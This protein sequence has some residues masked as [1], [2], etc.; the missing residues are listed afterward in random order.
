M[1]VLVTGAGGFIGSHVVDRLLAEGEEVVGLDNF[2]GFYAR[3]IKDANVG[4]ARDSERFELIEGDIRSPETLAS[5]PPDVDAVI[6]LAA[7]AGVRPSIADPVL[8]S[9]VNLLGTSVLLEFARARGIGAFVFASSSSVYG[10]NRK[11]PFSEDDAVDEPISPYAATK[12]AGELLCHTA[13]HLTGMSCCCLRF[14]TAYGPRQRPDLA[15]RTFARLLLEGKRIPRFGDGSTAR[16]YTYVDDVVSGVLAALSRVRR[17]S[18][19]FDIVNLGSSEPI[20]LSHMIAMVGEAFGMDPSVDELPMQ[21]GDVVRTFADTA[22]AERLLAY[23]PSTTF[24]DGLARFATWYR[25][26]GAAQ[27]RVRVADTG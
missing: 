10:N 20:P 19:A 13:V 24:R 3:A 11:T 6:H 2:D 21:P 15:I 18:G 7:R 23:R 12:R 22:K 9:D 17:E 4:P 8:Y 1:S 16:D 27:D 5:L 25:A 26:E 14:F